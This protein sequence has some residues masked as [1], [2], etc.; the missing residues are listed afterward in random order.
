M[1]PEPYLSSRARLWIALAVLFLGAP[2]A[3]YGLYRLSLW[4]WPI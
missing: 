2:P 3:G 4:I 1:T